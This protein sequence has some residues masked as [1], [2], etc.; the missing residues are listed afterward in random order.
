MGAPFNR[1]FFNAVLGDLLQAAGAD[2]AHRLSLFLTDGTTLDVCRIDEM[3]DEYL[4]LHTFEEDSGTCSLGIEVVPYG[5]I[6][7]LQ[8]SSKGGADDRVGFSW[9][10]AAKP[11]RATKKISK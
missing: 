5:L 1:T 7:R 9:K 4:V 8:V 10:P 3:S 6:Y 11:S 2:R